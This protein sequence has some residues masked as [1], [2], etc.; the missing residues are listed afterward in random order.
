MNFKQIGLLIAG[1]LAGAL[2]LYAVAYLY[3]YYTATSSLSEMERELEPF[4]RLSHG[5]IRVRPFGG[6]QIDDL[7]LVL[8]D[9]G[10]AIRVERI[11]VRSAAPF[12]MPLSMDLRRLA[13][14]IAQK[15][16]LVELTGLKMRRDDLPSI[17]EVGSPS[18]RDGPGVAERLL[19]GLCGVDAGEQTRGYL[20]RILPSDLYMSSRIQFQEG[21]GAGDDVLRIGVNL[22]QVGEL[23]VDVV[24]N[25]RHLTAASD[26]IDD[27]SIRRVE[28]RS[29]LDTAFLSVAKRACASMRDTTA[30][31]IDQLL[32]DDADS[33]FGDVLGLVPGDALL[34]ALHDYL[35]GAEVQV[36]FD[37]TA[38]DLAGRYAPEDVAEVIGLEVYVEGE[39]LPAPSFRAPRA[40]TERVAA[41]EA[42]ANVLARPGDKIG[43]DVVARCMGCLVTV[44]L[45]DGRERQGIADAM[46]GTTLYIKWYQ[47]AYVRDPGRSSARVGTVTANVPRADIDWIR[48][49]APPP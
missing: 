13:L 11:A 12:W 21:P 41:A 33:I 32:I 8:F 2:V 15:R 17:S 19:A 24:A 31:S 20:D 18:R 25:M 47:R 3:L 39:Q 16:L 48:F 9:S 29:R 49:D 10:R 43:Y 23:Q 4:G 27:S 45:K 42:D 6:A 14:A 28:I 22:L 5:A 37:P 1:A 35:S 36:S 26:V 44:R 34:D 38:L 7:E 30:E 40:P 46:D